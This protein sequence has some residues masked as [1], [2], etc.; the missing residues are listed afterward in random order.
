M[1]LTQSERDLLIEVHTIVTR[2]DKTVNGNGR[3]GLVQD[4]A[5]LRAD[6]ESLAEEVHEIR[7]LVPSRKEKA[8]GM[9]GVAVAAVTSIGAIVVAV[10]TKGA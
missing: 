4:Q 8:A 3:P 7:S 1:A 9:A 5:A 2:L 10:I 6:H